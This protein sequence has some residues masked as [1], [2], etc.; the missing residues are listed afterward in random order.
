MDGASGTMLSGWFLMHDRGTAVSGVRAM[1]ARL[2]RSVPLQV[3]AFALVTRLLLA[4][5]AWYIVKLVP[6][7]WEGSPKSI[8]AW[9]QWDAEHYTRIASNGYEHPT[10]PGSPAFFPLYPLL[11]KG[12]GWLTGLDDSWLEIQVSGVLVAWICFFIA[13]ALITRLFQRLVDDDVARTAGVLLCISPFSFFFTAGYTESLFLIFVALTFLL[14]LQRRWGWAAV[15]VALATACRVTGVFLIPVLLFMAW[16][17]RASLPALVSVAVVS[18]LG[19]LAYMAYTWLALD[20]PLAF[21]HAQEGWGGFYDRTGIYIVGFLDHPVPWFFGNASSPVIVLNV[22]MLLAWLTTL[23][24]MPRIAGL[25]ITVFS[26]VVILQAA[27]SF[28]SLG[29]YLLPAIGVYLVLAT[30]LESPRVP[31][32]VRDVVMAGSVILMTAL[33][34]LFS[35]AEWVV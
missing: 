27:T 23:V 7:P 10:D 22:A 32:V 4:F 35:Q 13:V 11:T 12:F 26:A 20:D 30:W 31:G 15:A 33:L 9:S 2:A 5:V 28:H 8:L 25:E 3:V 17:R 24:P 16:R 29:R 6:P 19:I 21:L 34:V 18:P 1:T 14:A